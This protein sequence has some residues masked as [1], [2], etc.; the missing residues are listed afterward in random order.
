MPYKNISD[1]PDAVQELPETT[2]KAWMKAFNTAVYDKGWK[3]DRAL[4][5]AWGAIKNKYNIDS[6]KS[7]ANNNE[8]KGISYIA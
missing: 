3:E 7:N 8:G 1:L 4:K 2:Q 6:K 5:Y